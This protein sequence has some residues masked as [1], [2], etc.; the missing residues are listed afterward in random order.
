MVLA[1]KVFRGFLGV[2]HFNTVPLDVER[3][4]NL[5]TYLNPVPEKLPFSVIFFLHFHFKAFF[6]L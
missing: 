6:I 1:G 3:A 2:T 5:F 4:V